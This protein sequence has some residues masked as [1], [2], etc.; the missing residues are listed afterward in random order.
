MVANIGSGF[1]FIPRPYPYEREPFRLADGDLVP[2]RDIFFS[3]PAFGLLADKRL[4]TEP[5]D[6]PVASPINLY[7]NKDA[8]LSSGIEPR[9]DASGYVIATPHYID[10]ILDM[11]SLLEDVVALHAEDSDFDANDFLRSHLER[12]R[13]IYD[14]DNSSASGVDPLEYVHPEPTGDVPVAPSSVGQSTVDLGGLQIQDI[15]LDEVMWQPF[16]RP[17][18]FFLD[19]NLGIPTQPIF[20]AAV[21]GGSLPTLSTFDREMFDD[22]ALGSIGS[23][24]FLVTGDGLTLG[25][26]IKFLTGS[27]QSFVNEG[28]FLFNI[29]WALFPA[30]EE[31]CAYYETQNSGVI[32]AS[33]RQAIYATPGAG[34]VSADSVHLLNVGEAG[35]SGFLVQNY[36]SDYRSEAG[37]NDAS[38]THNGVHNVEKLIYPITNQIAGRLT[39]GRSP[40]NGKRV[41]GHFLGTDTSSNN[42]NAGGVLAYQNGNTIN[43]FAGVTDA[44]VGPV[45]DGVSEV[46]W[47]TT[48]P[49]LSPISWVPSTT[50]SFQPRRGFFGRGPDQVQFILTDQIA[51]NASNPWFRLYADFGTIDTIVF[52]GE[53]Q[54]GGSSRVSEVITY[55][56]N[57]FIESDG[58][59]IP[60][61]DT[62]TST[63]NFSYYENTYFCNNIISFFFG[64]R[65]NNGL[66]N[67][68]GDPYLQWGGDAANLATRPFNNRFAPFGETATDVFPATTRSVATRTI[69]FFPIWVVILSVT[70]NN[71]VEFPTNIDFSPAAS[72]VITFDPSLDL[73]QGDLERFGPP[74]WDPDNNVNYIYF[75]V[76]RTGG[77]RS[78]FA[79]MNTSFVITEF[80]EVDSG[81]AIINGKTALLPI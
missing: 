23:G 47:G 54:G 57:E 70:T 38:G 80:H 66:Q 61:G 56:T 50:T 35:S 19:E 34:A 27:G 40:I 44:A 13:E 58:G 62:V 75:T 37:L 45:I 49:T 17:N 12:N 77:F 68:N 72:E 24:G 51:A 31:L 3:R 79:K 55:V 43:Y 6:H 26:T 25:T 4:F 2:Y 76:R 46:E 16:P 69:G 7:I 41:F 64:R 59:F 18:K 65:M 8:G 1:E 71:Q 48:G 60:F 53:N 42:R 63:E 21:N 73:P 10:Y 78:Y 81:D 36:P 29:P 67:V 39:A 32:T 22:L 30:Q 74:T 11:R 52:P 5:D 15:D 20:P 28:N 14:L 33:G 9:L